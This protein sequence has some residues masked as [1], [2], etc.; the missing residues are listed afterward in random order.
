MPDDRDSAE[1]ELVLTRDGAN[2]IY[3]PPHIEVRAGPPAAG[4]PEPPVF[5]VPC[6]DSVG[7][8]R[9]RHRAEILGFAIGGLEATAVNQND[10][11]V[12]SGAIRNAQFAVLIRVGTVGD[13]PVRRP[14]RKSFHFLRSH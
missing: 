13:A 6:C 8:E 5:Y 7:F 4:L 14:T 3:S 2:V 11:G 10:E 9:I 1:I 12:R